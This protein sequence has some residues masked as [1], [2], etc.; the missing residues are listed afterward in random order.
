MTKKQTLTQAMIEA[1]ISRS[2]LY[3]DL[4]HHNDVNVDAIERQNVVIEDLLTSIA[5][6]NEVLI[7]YESLFNVI[8][9]SAVLQDEMSDV[10]TFG[11]KKSTKTELN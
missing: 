10:S 6:I 1:L 9:D 11:I 7:R 4:K 3:Q 5:N 8:F 2:K